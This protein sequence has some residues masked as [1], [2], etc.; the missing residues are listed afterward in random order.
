MRHLWSCIVVSGL[1]LAVSPAFANDQP[2]VH[3]VSVRAELAPLHVPGRLWSCCAGGAIQAAGIVVGTLDFR[4]PVELEAMVGWELGDGNILGMLARWKT[5][6]LDPAR[7]R[8][9]VGAGIWHLTGASASAATVLHADLG[10]EIR[11]AGPVV[12]FAAIGPE[13]GLN[14]AAGPGDESEHAFQSGEIAYRGRLGF[15]GRFGFGGGD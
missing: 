6:W 11:I 3:S 1:V 10:Y 15:G 12:A 9:S 13:I 2:I 8:L 4:A 7:H 5:P 14:N